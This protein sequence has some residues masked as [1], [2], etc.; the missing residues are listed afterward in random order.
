MGRKPRDQPRLNRYGEEVQSL[1]VALPVDA[2]NILKERAK[3]DNRTMVS[4]LT[5]VLRARVV[6][7]PAPEG[8]VV[9]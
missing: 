8:M 1:T 3:A 4:F 7:D 2:Y 9:L 6:R 5:A